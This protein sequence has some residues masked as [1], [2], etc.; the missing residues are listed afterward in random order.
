MSRWLSILQPRQW[1]RLARAVF[2]E[3]KYSP[4]SW[5]LSVFDT[6]RKHP[7]R[8]ATVI[9]LAGTTFGAGVKIHEWREAHRPRPRVLAPERLITG[10]LS[11]PVISTVNEGKVRFANLELHLSEPTAALK[12]VKQ[13]NPPGI[14]LSPAHPGAWTWEN[15]KR[16][17]F[18]P[19][20]DWPPGKSFTVTLNRDQMAKEAKFKETPKWTF[21]TPAMTASLGEAE[22][23]T[24]PK[25]P[26]I[27]QVTAELRF[28]HPM[29]LADVERLVQMNPVGTPGLYNYGG[30]EPAKR[31][32]VTEDD[33]GGQRHFWLRSARIVLPEKEDY[34]AISLEKGATSSLGGEPVAAGVSGKVSVPDKLSGF[35]ISKVSTDLIRT[36]EGEPEQFLFV[37]TDGYAAP[38]EIAKNVHAWYISPDVERPKETPIWDKDGN[39][40]AAYQPLVKSVE[41][42][43]VETEKEESAPVATRHGFKFLNEQPGELLVHVV[44]GTNALGGFILGRTHTATV[45]V[46]EFP[47]EVELL[48]AGGVLAINGERKVSIKSRGIKNLRLTLGRVPSSQVNH[49]ARFNRGTFETPEMPYMIDEEHLAHFHRE[50]IQVPVRN[51]YQAAFT[52]FD[53]SAAL[54][55]EDKSDADSSRGMYFVLLEGV[56]ERPEGDDEAT[57][58]DPLIAK[59]RPIS[60]ASHRRFILVTDL[61]IIAKRNADNGRDLFVQSVSKGEPLAGV[62]LTVLA[63]NGEFLA[64]VTTDGQGHAMLPNLEVFHRE[65]EPVAITARLGN[66]LAFM[67]FKRSDRQ[68]ELSRFDTEGIV[69]E[70]LQTLR[71][72]V[73]TERGVY[74]P[75]DAIHVGAVVRRRDWGGEMKG[76]PVEFKVY[77]AKGNEV[78]TGKVNLPPDGFVEWITSTEETDPT[79]VYEVTVSRIVG[80]EDREQIGRSAFRLE[81]FEPDRMKMSAKL[82]TPPGLAWIAPSQVKGLVTVETLFGTAAAKRRVEAKLDLSPAHF[83]FDEFPDYTFH[84]RKGYEFK[85]GNDEDETAAGKKV[86]LGELTTNELGVA[87]FDLALERFDSGSFALRFSAEAFEPDG[88]RSVQGAANVLVSAMPYVVGFKA[89]SSLDYIGQDTPLALKYLCVGPDL[90]PMA[91]PALKA[92]IIRIRYVSV[93]TKQSNGNY[94]YVSTRR[95]KPESENPFALPATGADLK[96]PSNTAGEYRIELLDGDVVVSTCPFTIVGKGDPGRSLER[97]TELELKLARSDWNTGDSI[98]LNVNAPYTGAGLITIERD[99]VLSWQWFKSPTTSMNASIPLPAMEGSGYVSVA[100]VR[101]LDSPEIFTSPLS[102]AVA[103]FVANKDAHRLGV[104]LEAPAK[105][106]PGDALRIRYST[107]EPGRVVVFAVDEGIHQITNYKLPQPLTHFMEKRALEVD[108]YQLLDLILPE[109]SMVAKSSAF[110]GDDEEALTVNLNPFKRKKDAPVVYWSGLVESGP[111]AREVTYDVP[112]YFDGRLKI[113]AVAVSSLKLGSTET[114][115]LVRGPMVLTPNVPTFVAPG[116]E[117]TVSLSVAN[118]VDGANEVQLKLEPTE[119]VELLDPAETK[120]A[121]ASGKEETT[122]FRLKARDNLGGAELH[123]TGVAGSETVSRR[124][125]LS[126]RP[127]A[128]YLT[129]VKSGYFRRDTQDVKLDRAVY[130]HFRKAEAVV[131]ALPLGL[132]RGLEAYLVDYPHGCSEQITSRA[133][134]RLLLMNEADFGFDQAESASQLQSAFRLLVTRQNSDGGFGYW[135]GDATTDFLSVYVTQFLTVANEEGHALP[136]GLM[137]GA[138][139]RMK[140]IARS[141]NAEHGLRA[142]AIYLMTRNGEVTTNFVLNLRDTLEKSQKDKWQGTT[143]GAYLAGTYALLKQQGEG[144]KIMRAWWSKCDKAPKLGRWYYGWYNDPQ[145]QQAQGFGLLCRHFPDLGKTLGYD[146]LAM[147]TEPIRAGHFNTYSAAYGVLALKAYSELVQKADVKLTIQS[148]LAD[149]TSSLL[150]PEGTGLRR[151]KFDTGLNGMRFLLDKNGTD[152]GAYYQVSESGYD[153]QA[154]GPP[155]AD[156]LEVFREL[157]DSKGKPL[158]S[159]KVGEEVTVRIR[160]RNNS[161]EALTNVAVLDLLPGGFLLA[162]NGLRPGRGTVPDTDYV[163]VREDRS[164]FYLGLDKGQTVTIEYG[165]KP[166]CAGKF[167]V[168]PVFAE[169][170]YDRGVKGRAGGGAVEVQ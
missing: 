112:D 87:E 104:T 122:R 86:D 101:A 77:D 83:A 94:E 168:P 167:A 97:D 53:F 90:K 118:N 146:D 127:A 20:A 56:E 6:M 40:T 42:K 60:G 126:V 73:F 159:L 123:F 102:Y 161:P 158:A 3:M 130:P 95:E 1:G 153:K 68:L 96:L 99:K 70:E 115:S 121:V 106:K 21:T 103:P 169:C 18:V 131:S 85:G 89:P 33:Q 133:M 93:L 124:G 147:I 2:G 144:D 58:P 165:I 17:V 84:N 27:H 11:S 137:S 67:P 13:A 28:S 143:A 30:K 152:L 136:E 47:K 78:K 5:P 69:A 149:G 155:I 59:W 140:Q 109:F 80:E 41:L 162:P 128:P 65:K 25:D 148:L 9:V 139:N 37:D 135:A 92:R 117:F 114:Q 34:V 44:K 107:A 119:Q 75:G 108:T 88:G 55:R 39:L 82:S 54:T 22:F 10:K 38:E 98:S 145:V 125:T 7:G 24:D 52:T 110:G 132:A 36:A 111:E 113:M 74:R 116:D 134:S 91:A 100:Y 15:D 61:G 170:M 8:W 138:L 43:M 160:V 163:D 81:D 164:I 76:L 29:K 23:Y 141:E 26:E 51:E 120:L 35:H 4:P 72:F 62:A 66:D 150:L 57:D 154:L 19:Q 50:L 142:A 32:T 156:G 105:V 71:A 12:D 64:Q 157:L 48:G 45:D 16:L 79:G 151:T 46:P 63:K 31:F 166:V 49:L 14:A 129:E